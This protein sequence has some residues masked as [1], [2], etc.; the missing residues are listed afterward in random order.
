MKTGDGNGLDRE[1]VDVVVDDIDKM[2][3]RD[4]PT[5]DHNQGQEINKTNTQSTTA[6]TTGTQID[7]CNANGNA[8]HKM[9]QL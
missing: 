1:C 8:N 3:A 5:P 2:L 7:N 6:T 4:V 9:G